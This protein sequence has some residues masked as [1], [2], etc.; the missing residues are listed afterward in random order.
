MIKKAYPLAV[1]YSKAIVNGC[2][3]RNLEIN[4]NKLEQLLILMQ[5]KMLTENGRPLF[6]NNIVA[7]K[8]K[9]YIPDVDKAFVE[10]AVGCHEKQYETVAFLDDELEIVEE[11]LDWYAEI[12]P[13]FLE[14]NTYLKFLDQKALKTTKSEQ[15][16]VPNEF[17][18][19]VFL[20]SP[21]YLQC[22]MNK[23][24]KCC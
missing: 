10:Y 23:D 2:L 11:T 18:E 9:V 5:G 1:E 4:T 13:E 16:V 6:T 19:N 3:E 12:G 21:E 14:N 22:C 8:T 17:I 7:T 24:E 20:F 15:Q